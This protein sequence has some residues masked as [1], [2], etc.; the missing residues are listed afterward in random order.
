MGE[1]KEKK[2]KHKKKA[3]YFHE[4]L[5]GTVYSTS[6]YTLCLTS[7]VFA[8]PVHHYWDSL[9]GPER[10]H[11]FQFFI[12]DPHWHQEL[13]RITGAKSEQSKKEGEKERGGE[14]DIR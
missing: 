4:G 3:A 9:P 1:R 13:L 8:L 7:Y 2:K 14:R 10:G 11:T 6:M 12:C 5:K